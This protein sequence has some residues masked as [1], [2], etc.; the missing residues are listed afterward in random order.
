[1]TEPPIQDA[2]RFCPSCSAA[3]AN[4]GSV[5]FRCEHCG[6]ANFFGPV[7]AV[8]GLIVDD[9]NRLLMVRRARNPGLGKW[10]LPGGFV[11]QRES[12]EEALRREIREET[13]LTVGRFTY[14]MSHPNTYVYKGVAAPVI[15][16]FFEC[17]V[18]SIDELSL[19]EDELDFHQWVR[20][21]NE[22]LDHMAFHSNRLA[23]ERWLAVTS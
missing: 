14:L 8:G 2:Y 23:I 10:G 11:D 22:H 17:R 1:M 12:I 15:D 16:L 20:P 21:G 7:S 18:D 13:N 5:P 3:N 19:A 4:V 6:F 9:Q